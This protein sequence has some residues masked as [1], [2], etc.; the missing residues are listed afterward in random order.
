MVKLI[1]VNWVLFLIDLV[2]LK[3]ESIVVLLVWNRILVGFMF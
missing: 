3:F 1:W 2:M